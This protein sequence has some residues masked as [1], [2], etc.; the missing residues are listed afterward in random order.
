MKR[1]INPRVPVLVAC[2]LA[3]GVLTGYL[4]SYLET[5]ILW[6]IAVV[7]CTA[8]I[9]IFCLILK[10]KKFLILSLVFALVFTGG[11]LNSYFTIQNYRVCDVDTEKIYDISGVVKEKGS[12]SYGEYIIIDGA[13]AGDN[14]L[15][16]K[17]R[18][19]L[20]ETY[21]DF[22]DVGYNVKF[23][24]KLN[25]NDAFP[26]GELNYYAEDNVK[27]TCFPY[28]ELTSTYRFSLFGSIRSV[29]KNTLYDNLSYDTASVC[30]GMMLGDTQ[31]V[32]DDALE[33]FRYG[34]IAHIFAVSGLHIGLV[35]GVLTF[36]LKKLR[37][38]K[39]VSAAVRLFAI[40]FYAGICGFAV[41]SVRA[42]IMCGINLLAGL[43]FV[44]SDELNN[45][46][47]ATFFILL[48]SPLSLFSVGFQLS[49]CAIGGILLLSNG[50]KRT[51]KRIKIPAK[52]SAGVGA[53]IGAQA[54]TFPV[55]LAKFGYISGAGLLL[56]LL[57]IPIV[58]I[59]F[60]ILF[61]GTVLSLVIPPAAGFIMQYA[62]MP[63]E[64]LLSFLL[65]A[66]FE[67]AVISGFGAGIFVPLYFVALLF[68]SDKINLKA[69]SRTV[70]ATC[71]VAVLVVCVLVQTYTPA[72]G[73]KVTVS[74]YTHG[75]SVL[76]KSPQGNILIMTEG[77]SVSRIKNCL[78]R[79]YCPDLDGVV[80]IG[81]D[82]G[83]EAYDLNL[84]CTDVY[85]CS[86]NIPVQP[87]RTVEVH[88][89]KDFTLCG[90]DFGYIDGHN[91]TAL[92]DGVEILLSDA[93]NLPFES[94]DMLISLYENYDEDLAVAPCKAE[95][96]VYFNLPKTEYN[97]YDYGDLTFYIKDGNI[98]I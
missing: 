32:D 36:L 91:L 61:A 2:T 77:A 38:H 62:A 64:A 7:P 55:M 21:G 19:Y 35:Y 27:Y 9:F 67:K 75:G 78:N 3:L 48:V 52:I 4:F 74:A 41:S 49:V 93:E 30:Y 45:L 14:K 17:I 82:N 59:L 50:I 87:Y 89:E 43:F 29:I 20:N 42:V 96:T 47:F 72:S 69:V 92:V 60:T 15:S 39:Y 5:N 79:E 80:I 94:C 95:Y 68:L 83:V 31:N 88:Y 81:G 44:K 23:R 33:N 76:M 90:I 63:L 56:N 84:N 51:L 34:G 22:C 57:I 58:S 28:S 86:L 98:D 65:A 24:A 16:G 37:I 40:I 46:G 6:L 73:Y 53:S 13:K 97:A 18:V 85:V 26:Y 70:L 11:A 25:F 8:I 12:T 54:G 1:F 10:K 71:S 66:N